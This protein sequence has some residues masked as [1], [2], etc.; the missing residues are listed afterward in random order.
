VIEL[1]TIEQAADYLG[2]SPKWVAA[3]ARRGEIPS[4]LVGRY[5]RF[6][7]DDLSAY[8]DSIRV[9]GVANGRVTRRRKA[10]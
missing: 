10:S 1:L 6:T 5:R 7:P 3:A 4:R 2:R 9:G 8:I